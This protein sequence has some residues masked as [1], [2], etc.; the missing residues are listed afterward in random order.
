MLPTAFAVP[1]MPAVHE[2]V[3]EGAGQ[4]QEV[5]EDPKQMRPVFRDQEERSDR[6]ESE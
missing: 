6:E 5:R 3:E 1:P 4:Q 2:Q